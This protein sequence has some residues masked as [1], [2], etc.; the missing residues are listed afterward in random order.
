MIPN[1]T[2]A[3]APAWVLFTYVSF[4]VSLGAL[5]I[6]I[7]MLPIDLWMRGFLFMGVLMVVQS[8]ITMTKTQRDLHEGTRLMNR[9]EDAKTEKLLMETGRV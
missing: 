4:A 5:T 6:G 2:A 8:C 1:P 7:I 9:I 3:H